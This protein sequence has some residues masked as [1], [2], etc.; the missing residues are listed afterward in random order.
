MTKALDRL[1]MQPDLFT[2]SHDYGGA[3]DTHD[4]G[5][6]YP[7]VMAGERSESETPG[8]SVSLEQ[9]KIQLGRLAKLYSLRARAEGLEKAL[10]TPAREEIAPRLVY[11][12]YVSHRAL[13]KTAVAESTE[14][15]FLSYLVKREELLAAGFNEEDID[16]TEDATLEEIRDDFGVN[17]G[18]EQ[19]NKNL[20][21][22]NQH[23]KRR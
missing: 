6:E 13:E 9:R 8:V 4:S 20:K 18:Y 22:L 21:I 11:P 10:T 16:K 1:N 2:S 15:F 14:R 3:R 23:N 5:H 17:T 7:F 12:E 19:R